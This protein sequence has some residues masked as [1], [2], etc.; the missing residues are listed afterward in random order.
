MDSNHGMT[1][2]K[3]L[4]STCGFVGAAALVS[5]GGG[6]K[7]FAAGGAMKRK[8]QEG[9]PRVGDLLVFAEDKRK[10]EFVALD[11]LVMDGAPV[12]VLPK[13][14]STGTV[15]EDENSKILLLRSNPDKLSPELKEAAAEGVLA[16]S[17][18][19]THLGCVMN[20]W[21]E[22]KKLFVCPCHE[23]TFDPMK[24]GKVASGPGPRS[25]P[26]LPLKLASNKFIVADE[27]SGFVG[28][29]KDE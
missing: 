10:G 24:E 20:Q 3:L 5:V 28:A 16:Y 12:L 14:P 18:L 29:K 26:I 6:L 22:G 19:C 1:R 23:A 8:K 15:R 21:N 11:D 9:V 25:L 4:K 27:F 17:A 7:V 2:R 13:D